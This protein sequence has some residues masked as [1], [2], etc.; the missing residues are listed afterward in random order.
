VYKVNLA[1]Q[2]VKKVTISNKTENL[3][4]KKEKIWLN[5]ILT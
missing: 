4:N 3:G 5:N 1:A 2:V